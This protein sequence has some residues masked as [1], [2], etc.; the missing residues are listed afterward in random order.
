MLDRQVIPSQPPKRVPGASNL[1]LLAVATAYDEVIVGAAE[2]PKELRFDVSNWSVYCVLTG[3][4]I[5][6]YDVDI[7]RGTRRSYQSVG[8]HKSDYGNWYL[9]RAVYENGE[10]LERWNAE[11]SLYGNYGYGSVDRSRSEENRDE[12]KALGLLKP[13][14]A[15][16]ALLS[17][18][19]QSRAPHIVAAGVDVLRDIRE[20]TDRELCSFVQW[21]VLES[22]WAGASYHD[23]PMEIY[24][25]TYARQAELIVNGQMDNCVGV[26][27]LAG[28]GEARIVRSPSHERRHDG[29]M[30]IQGHVVDLD[31]LL[32]AGVHVSTVGVE[33]G[34]PAWWALCL[35]KQCSSELLF[36][37]N[38][39]RGVDDTF[40]DVPAEN[41]E[42]L[43]GFV[44]D[45]TIQNAEM[46]AK[47]I[48]NFQRAGEVPV[49]AADGFGLDWIR[50]V[51]NDQCFS[52]ADSIMRSM[53]WGQQV[54]ISGIDIAEFAKTAIPENS[55][56]R[57]V[58][59]LK[60][61][62]VRV[63]LKEPVYPETIQR[64]GAI[65]AENEAGTVLSYMAV[66]AF[67]LDFRG[68]LTRF[69]N[70][71]AYEDEE[72]TRTA[73]HTNITSAGHVCLGD[74]N[75]EMSR[76]EIEARGGVA[77]PCVADFIQMLKQ[78]NLDSAYNRGREFVLAD[79]SI[80][81]DQQWEARDWNI[82][83]LRRIDAHLDFKA[84]LGAQQGG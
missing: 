43:V 19:L 48:A 13:D 44:G 79:P 60:N 46:W 2:L 7:N 16:R 69:P 29:E 31:G 22:Q 56:V 10:E 82:P 41:L 14:D 72:C 1:S 62:K 78:C 68:T 81:T 39:R 25:M 67:D 77:M 28:A 32:H 40:G 12:W 36:A 42:D 59:M 30:D 76:E 63:V 38:R 37:L 47:L 64:R 24:A 5:V 54:E 65:Y 9:V 34:S 4:R 53:R 74:I 21:L 33:R 58:T 23:M 71:T 66:H 83:G 51:V 27:N 61:G 49:V 70:A 55:L 84:L 45:D 75:T 17:G 73:R 8:F 50:R 20:Y 26:L 11:R 57:S 35:G 18:Y 52:V 80:V 3:R 6:A 15:L